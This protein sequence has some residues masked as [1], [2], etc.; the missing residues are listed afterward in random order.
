[1]SYYYDEKTKTNRLDCHYPIIDE[2]AI[3]EIVENSLARY[4][5][6]YIYNDNN[7]MVDHW[8]YEVKHGGFHAYED[9]EIE[10]KKRIKKHVATLKRY[11]KES[12]IEYIVN[13]E[14]ITQE[15]IRSEL[16]NYFNLNPRTVDEMPDWM[17]MAIWKQG[18]EAYQEHIEEEEEHEKREYENQI[19]KRGKTI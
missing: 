7:V 11:I 19:K 2:E 1:M 17:A 18:P 8:S 10:T 16:K 6:F 14:K 9:P 13:A 3:K 15:K 5:Y 4:I 12:Y